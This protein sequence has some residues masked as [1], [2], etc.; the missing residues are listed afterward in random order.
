MKTKKHKYITRFDYNYTHGWQFRFYQPFTSKFF[1]DSKLG[2]KSKALRA[3]ILYRNKTLK[4]L[5]KLASLNVDSVFEHSRQAN[6]TSGIIGVKLFVDPRYNTSGSW[7]A[8]GI[9]KGRRWRRTFS[10]DAYGY[11]QAFQHAC[12]TRHNQ[13]GTLI[14][15]C[16][17]G[18]LP[19]T[20]LAPFRKV[21]KQIDI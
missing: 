21:I 1:T 12:K 16:D 15:T 13:H 7:H 5:G 4:K 9:I 11:T 17:V 6:N 10:I 2:S 14:L 3:A 20:P 8:E 18:D 19:A